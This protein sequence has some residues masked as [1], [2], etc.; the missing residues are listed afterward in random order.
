VTIPVFVVA[1]EDDAT[2]STKDTIEFFKN[3]KNKLN[4]M[5]LYSRRDLSPN[6]VMTGEAATSVEIVKSNFPAERILSSAHTAIVLPASDSHYGKEGDYKN[7]E[8]YFGESEEK[9]RLCKTGQADFIGEIGDENL[10]MGVV[11]RLMYNPNYQGMEQ[12]LEKFI[13]SLS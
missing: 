4:Q 10:S 11:Q 1:S 2:V 6:E 7:C 12:S 5:I 3:A 13:G 9:Y 8:H